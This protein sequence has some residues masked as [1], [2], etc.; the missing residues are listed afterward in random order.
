MSCKMKNYELTYRKIIE[1]DLDRTIVQCLLIAFG[2][3]EAHDMG[4]SNHMMEAYF[5]QLRKE[6]VKL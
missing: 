1:L 3:L 6:L 4:C 2:L 5:D